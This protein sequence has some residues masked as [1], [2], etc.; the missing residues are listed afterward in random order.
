MGP[1]LVAV[2][3][4]CQSHCSEIPGSNSAGKCSVRFHEAQY[5]SGCE[6]WTVTRAPGG[7]GVDSSHRSL[8]NNRIEELK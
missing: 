2:R 1:T 7:N 6:L 8:S 5:C 3:P 4:F